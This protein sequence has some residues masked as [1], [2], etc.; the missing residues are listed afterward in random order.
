MSYPIKFKGRNTEQGSRFYLKD[1]WASDSGHWI[2]RLDT[3]DN[4][5]IKRAVKGLE[6]GIHAY[7]Y[8]GVTPLKRSLIDNVKGQAESKLP[9]RRAK[10]TTEAKMRYDA[11]K[12]IVDCMAVKVLSEP[13]FGST[14]VVAWVSPTY[15]HLLLECERVEVTE[16]LKPIK[17]FKAGNET[18]FPDMLVMPMKV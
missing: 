10:V 4:K 17:G 14:D 6:D 18:D 7:G 3:I 15:V 1:G 2:A 8:D 13:L 9:S 16:P 5:S 11:E 12:G